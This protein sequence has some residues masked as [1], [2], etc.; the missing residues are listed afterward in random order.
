MGMTN[1]ARYLDNPPWP[2]Y[3]R[4]EVPGWD[5][6]PTDEQA[7]AYQRALGEKGMVLEIRAPE[8]QGGDW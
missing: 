1:N 5:V 2:H 3:Y 6:W 7:A 4:R 8:R